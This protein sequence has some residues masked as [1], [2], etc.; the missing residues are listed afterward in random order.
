MAQIRR[1]TTVMAA[2]IVGFSILMGRDEEGT[3]HRLQSLLNDIVAPVFVTRGG[4]M[5]KTT[6][7]GLLA[8]FASPLSAVEASAMIQGE[9]ADQ[10]ALRPA[11]ERLRLRIGINLGDLLVGDDGDVYGEGVNIAARLE[12]IAEPGGVA[13]SAKVHQEIDGKCRYRFADRGEIALKNIARPVRVYALRREAA[14]LPELRPAVA[15]PDKPSLAVLPFANMSADPDQEYFADGIVEDILTAVSRVRWLFVIAR[16]S[17]FTYKGRVVDVRQVGRELGVRYVLEGS[18]R[19]AGNRVRITGQ[20][21]EAE[22]GHHIWADRFDGPLDDIFELQD[23]VTA[24]VVAAIEPNLR[25][26][27]M[28]RA[29]AK[30][31]HQLDAYDLYLRALNQCYNFSQASFVEAERLLARALESD[32]GYSDAWALLAEIAARQVH[33]GWLSFEETTEKGC[34]Y[35][36]KAIETDP[37]NANSLASAALA[38]TFLGGGLDQAVD[39]AQRSVALHPNS[40]FVLT[41]S[42]IVFNFEAESEKAL[43]MLARAQRLSPIDP[44]AYVINHEIAFAHFFAMRFELAVQFAARAVDQNPR[45]NA[46]RRTLASSLA[47]LGRIEEAAVAIAALLEVQPNS[48]LRLSRR[49][50]FRHAWMVNLFCE[51]LQ[52]AGLPD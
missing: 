27:E 50:R 29:Q 43:A 36:A 4:R 24:A 18:V 8:E 47:H 14:A 5:I 37:G 15:L 19:K 31:T 33:G 12:S 22:T 32:P 46:A 52:R 51:G 28:R 25:S 3:F 49:N 42:A 11:D 41:S 20:L 13:I 1:L 39:Y 6:G 21:V 44:R 45:F 16:N 38:L 35:A 2:D 30:P 9:L 26:V 23:E 17:S 10:E 40:A 48:C 34:H 7:D